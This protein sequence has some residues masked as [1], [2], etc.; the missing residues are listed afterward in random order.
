MYTF[1]LVIKNVMHDA[2]IFHDIVVI[3]FF[4]YIDILR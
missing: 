2:C 4:V 3:P 1:S